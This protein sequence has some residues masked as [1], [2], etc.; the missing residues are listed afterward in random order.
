MRSFVSSLIP[1]D[2]HAAEPDVRVRVR[3]RI[4]QIDCKHARVRAVVPVT[5]TK[6]GPGGRTTSLENFNPLLLPNLS[7][8]HKNF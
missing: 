1:R 3:R 4:V 8:P 5:T 7:M 2:E 6:D